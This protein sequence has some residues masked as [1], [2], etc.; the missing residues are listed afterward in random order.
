MEKD[1]LLKVE[2]VSKSFPGVQ[3]LNKVNFTLKKGTV[4]ALCGENGAGK[5]TLMNVLMG[6]YKRDEGE[7]YYKGKKVNFD[8]PK[9]AL[10]V[11][12]SIIEQELNSIPDMTVAEN[13]FLGREPIKYSSLIN[14]SELNNMARN[15]LHRLNVDINPRVKMKKLSL[16]E[17][18]LVEIARAL[19][20]ESDVIIMDEPTSALGNKEVVKFFEVIRY[21]KKEGRGIIY[22]SHRMKEIFTIGDEVSILRDGQYVAT[23]KIS[24]IN[25]DGLIK[26]M[27]SRRL[28]GQYVKENIP[29]NEELLSVKNLTKEGQY[30]NISLHSN[31]GEIL[32]IFGLSGSG[33]SEFFNGL[34]GVEPADL[35]EIYIEGKRVNIKSPIDGLKQGLALVTEDRKKTG[36]LLTSTLKENISICSLKK[37]TNLLLINEKQEKKDVNKIVNRFNIKTPS[38]KQLVKNLSGG[39][40]QKLVLGKWI[41]TQPRILLLDEPT[42]GIDVASKREMYEFMS[43]FANE[44]GTIIMVSSELPE[45][46]G[47]S[48]RIV[49]FKKGEIMGE[50]SRKEANEK[51]LTTLAF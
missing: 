28:E 27:I 33:R 49:V 48:D 46:L 7:I 45:I 44:G 25:R 29:G 19:S 39:N 17:V 37:L 24:D 38:I 43:N 6:V 8:H 30:K 51:K 36:L 2:G 42:R 26:L 23:K 14:Y 3:A 5:S 34:F 4:H 47:M 31:R 18:Q 16:A 50:L 32:G 9:Q 10:K 15:I 11:G 22:V 21:L 1:I 41:L 12:I 35:G 40:Q 20:Y 13:I